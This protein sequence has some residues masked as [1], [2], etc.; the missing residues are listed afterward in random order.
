MLTRFP[1]P[2]HAISVRSRGLFV[3]LRFLSFAFGRLLYTQFPPG[4]LYVVGPFL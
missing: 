3:Y 1:L 4:D 2:P